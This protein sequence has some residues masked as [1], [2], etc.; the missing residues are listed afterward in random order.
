VYP[1]R[2]NKIEKPPSQIFPTLA[3]LSD[4]PPEKIAKS[5][6]PKRTGVWPSENKKL[7]SCP[8]TPPIPVCQCF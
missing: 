6:S 1:C 2:E 7:F 4:K 3:K 5:F 8:K